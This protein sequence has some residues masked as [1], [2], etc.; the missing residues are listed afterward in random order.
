MSRRQQNP[1]IKISKTLSYLL[2]HGAK[3][4]KIKMRTDG[5][6]LVSDLLEH[7]S[8]KRITF[9]DIKRIVE[10]NDKKRF[11]L[12]KDE[13]QNDIIKATQGHTIEVKDLS[14][15]KITK[16][17]LPQCAVH[18]TN[19]KNWNIIKN[20]GL[21]K[22]K[23]NHIHFAPKEPGKGQV[24]SGMRTSSEIM[25]FVDLEKALEDGIQ[26]FQSENEVI[27]SEGIDG[28]IPPKYFSKVVDS[29]TQKI[30][31]SSNENEK[32]KEK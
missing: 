11:L 27:L 26:F 3:K 14:L 2:R 19:R 24:I 9:E 4:E 22:M 12:S 29:K 5:F 30:I 15:T 17:N 10:N 31:F 21:S 6:V 23:R 28:I 32:E 25:I 7:R 20:Q 18:G 16:E 8:L 13:N 1:D